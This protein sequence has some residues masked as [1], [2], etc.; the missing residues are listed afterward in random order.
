MSRRRREVRER[1]AFV[2]AVR[3]G[4]DYDTDRLYSERELIDGT[5]APV[6]RNSDGD[7]LMTCRR[8]HKSKTLNRYSEIEGVKVK[9][10]AEDRPEFPQWASPI[11]ISCCSI[12]SHEFCSEGR[13]HMDW[14]IYD[15]RMSGRRRMMAS[16]SR[17]PPSSS[18]LA[19]LGYGDYIV[20]I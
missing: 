2:A 4:R 19:V 3:A 13:T 15:E 7:L 17:P 5:F 18:I 10:R 11:C 8:C 6:G 9:H 1:R 20:I 12:E 16:P 14:A